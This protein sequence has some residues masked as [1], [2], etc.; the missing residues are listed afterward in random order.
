MSR[1]RRWRGLLAPA[2]PRVVL[3]SILKALF[4]VEPFPGFPSRDTFSL[5]EAALAA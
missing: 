3:R 2:T 1:A 5:I 4:D